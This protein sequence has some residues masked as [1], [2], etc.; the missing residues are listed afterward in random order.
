MRTPF[1]IQR[2]DAINKQRDKLYLSRAF[3]LKLWPTTSC[4]SLSAKELFKKIF[5]I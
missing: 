2:S 3:I 1:I 5:Y 4:G